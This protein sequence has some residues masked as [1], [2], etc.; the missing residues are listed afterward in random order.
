MAQSA[1]IENAGNDLARFRHKFG[2]VND[3]DALA[4]HAGPIDE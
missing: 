3:Q 2:E 4:E 1:M